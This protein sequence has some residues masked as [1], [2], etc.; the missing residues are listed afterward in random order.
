M[1]MENQKWNEVSK[2]IKRKKKKR[3]KEIAASKSHSILQKD[4]YFQ[5]SY[6][7]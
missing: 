4:K 5:R 2:E 7:P 3:K 6:I 1:Y